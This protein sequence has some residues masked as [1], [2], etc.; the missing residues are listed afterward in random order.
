M[1]NIHRVKTISEFHQ[2]TGLPKPDHPLI[3]IVDYSA[4]EIPP[5]SD[6][7]NWIFDF[8][9]IAIKRGLN[10]KMKYGQQEYD[11]DDGVMFF[12]APNQVFRI[13][14]ETRSGNERSGWMLQ[15]HPKFLRNTALNKEIKQFEFFNYTVNE[16]L[17]LSENEEAK[18]GNI[19]QNIQQEYDPNID[20]FSQNIIISQINTLLGYSE[21]FYERQFLTRKKANHLVINRFEEILNNYFNYED[22]VIK[23]LPTVQFISES[24]NLSPSYLST[25]LKTLT[26]RS[27]R[28]HIQEQLIEKAREKLS[29]TDLTIGEIAYDLGFEHPQSFSKFFKSKTKLSPMKFRKS[30][31]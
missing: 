6:K 29:A 7:I 31:I 14:P 28:Q 12:I 21:R 27:P 23:G 18:I 11:F 3:S 15:F 13:E 19:V 17:F 24:L 4:I 25:L 10:A 8:Y 16:A 22:L 2:I 5:N 20:K 26:G 30:F 9:Q 1:S